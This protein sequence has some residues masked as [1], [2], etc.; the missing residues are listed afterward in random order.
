MFMIAIQQ[1]DLTLLNGDGCNVTING[2]QTVL[3]R[4]GDYLCYDD[5]RCKIL[6][7]HISGDNVQFAASSHGN[8][9]EPHVVLRSDEIEVSKDDLLALAH[10]ENKLIDAGH[11]FNALSDRLH[12]EAKAFVQAIVQLIDGLVTAI[13]DEMRQVD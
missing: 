10:A 6:D 7:E 11:D 3:R 5:N 8:E 13:N 1:N 2:K 9:D 12:G 4:E